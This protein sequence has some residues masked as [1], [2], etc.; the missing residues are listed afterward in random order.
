LRVHLGAH[1]TATT[2]FQKALHKH[3]A[4][5]RA[6]GIDFVRPVEFRAALA[7]ESG[8]LA[9]PW[10]ARAR[11]ERTLAGLTTGAPTL[12]ISEENLIGQIRDLFDAEPYRDLGRRLTPLVQLAGEQPLTLFLAIRPFD[13]LWASA[14][15]QALRHH[16]HDPARIERLRHI[17]RTVP[18][19]WTEVLARLRRACPR[20]AIH[21]WRY[22]DYEAHWRQIA[23]AFVGAD[24]GVIP[25]VTRPKG[26]MSPSAEGVRL[27]EQV[28]GAARGGEV[29]AIYAA[30][31]ARGGEP[32]APFDAA[33][34]AALR[35]AS[36]ADL[37]ALAA[38]PGTL[39]DFARSD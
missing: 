36:A 27:A 7:A 12:A 28:T 8:R 25:A 2:H 17:A 6:A 13:R 18:P 22:D 39:L 1:K 23:R 32:F 35:D 21:V 37:A 5:L 15:A 16:P 11:L 31:P 29:A 33:E 20:A 30:H 14:H 38:E 34:A 10:R 3:R 26:S 19:R 24:V 4:A 9:L